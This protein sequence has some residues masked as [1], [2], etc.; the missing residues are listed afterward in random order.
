MNDVSS[1]RE[2]TGDEHSGRAVFEIL[3][4]ENAD[5]L[6]S[7]IRSLV[8]SSTA[9]DDIFQETMITAW[10]RLDDYDRERPFAPWLRGI[11]SN[12]VMKHRQGNAEDIMHCEPQVLEAL[13]SRFEACSRHSDSFRETLDRLQ[14]CLRR[15]PD[16][17]R[18]AVE[19][20]YRGGL[21]LRQAA[22]RIGSSEEAVK[23]R[24]QRG[25]QLL[26]E[27]LRGEEEAS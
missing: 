18:Q 13:E 7:Y 15:L 11:A 1:R 22:R 26:A 25:R 20:M 6:V 19:L 3:A 14:F 21:K 8:R 12:M 23:K 24:V 10:R 5:M 9:V 4:R 2:E 16:K 27:C 17:L